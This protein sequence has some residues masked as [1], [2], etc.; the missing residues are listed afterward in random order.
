MHGIIFGELRKLVEHRL[1]S[2]GWNAILEDA[3]LESKLYIPVGEYP[4]ADA[5]AI[6]SAI[7]RNAHV[8]TQTILED[9][10]E[11][12]A[13]TL[14]SLYRHLIKPA[15]RTI[16]VLENTEQTI[17]RVVRTHN[18]GA[19]PPMLRV[20]RDGSGVLIHYTSSRK[21]CGVAVGIVRGLASHF[22]ER[23]F[24]QQTSCMLRGG[25]SC[26][27]SVKADALVRR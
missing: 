5:F 9:F 26:R 23:V 12:I 2:D 19:R 16:D 13:P 24:I 21:M 7:A 8:E 17:H 10:G 11:F 6:V 15:W 14:M 3:G 20:T 18:P 4:D 25:S 27:I 1:G 22:D